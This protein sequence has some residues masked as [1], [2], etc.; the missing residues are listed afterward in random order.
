MLVENDP[1]KNKP[2]EILREE[3][4]KGFE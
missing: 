2:F 4:A 3:V 1:A